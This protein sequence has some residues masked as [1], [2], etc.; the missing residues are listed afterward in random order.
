MYKRLIDSIL[1]WLSLL[2]LIIAFIASIKGK[3]EF[4]IKNLLNTDGL[5]IIGIAVA[6]IMN[7]ALKIPFLRK[8]FLFILMHLNFKNI[9]YKIQ[10]RCTSVNS[11][12]L[13]DI[14]NYFQE[15]I[16]KSKCYNSYKYNDLTKND[17]IIKFYH[18]GM[19]ANVRF[20]NI[21]ED[22]SGASEGA[23]CNEWLLEI[24]GVNKFAMLN[25]NVK[26]I[27]DHFLDSNSFK[28]DFEYMFLEIELN[29]SEIDITE[30]GGWINRK[31]YPIISSEFKLSIR[32]ASFIE[33]N[34]DG[35]C[36]TAYTKGEFSEGF[37]VLKLVLI[38]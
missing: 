21:T 27:I 33:K 30:I 32:E 38:S 31:K 2:F 20:K 15:T 13:N 36:L 34:N 10:L 17:F 29:N 7:L 8:I 6:F 3:T 28:I 12:T 14:F 18:R 19:A 1:S 9:D 4:S 22:V 26:Y 37:G 35:I 24:D 16:K 25:K 11:I 5:T 23:N